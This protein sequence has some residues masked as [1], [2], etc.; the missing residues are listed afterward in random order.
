[1]NHALSIAR[2]LLAAAAFVLPVA[3]LANPA[4]L[5]VPFDG[6]GNVSVFE[7]AAGTGG[8]TGS[9]DQSPFP[10]VPAP[11][12]L[13]SVVLFQLDAATQTLGGSFELTTTDLSST[14]F[15]TLSG[16]YAVADILNVGGQFSLDYAI[17]GGSG[18]FQ[19]A[20]GYG[21]SFLDFAPAPGAFDNYAEAGQLVFS[22]PEPGTLALASL[23]LLAVCTQASRRRRVGA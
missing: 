18:M 2:R 4:P 11:L 10:V 1:M 19:G 17:T 14:L 3:V 21:L 9:I 22:V 6:A 20:T 13:V 23:G 8:W 5:F 15:G 16:S 12:A 7:A